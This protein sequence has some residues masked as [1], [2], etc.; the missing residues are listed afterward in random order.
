MTEQK[1]HGLTSAGII[2]TYIS[3]GLEIFFLAPLCFLI[4]TNFFNQFLGLLTTEL[5]IFIIII[6]TH[7]VFFAIFMIFL[8][9]FHK[10]KIKSYILIGIMNLLF[11]NPLGGILILVGE[12]ISLN[13][14]TKSN[15]FD[16]L[17]V[18]LKNLENLFE[19]NIITKDEYE[20]KRKEIINRY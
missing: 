5:L 9:L 2:L 6:I 15:T 17:E 11:F 3:F 19:K 14:K 12:S 13:N 1:Y 10:R 8:I 20:T 7:I 18:K 16:N 4:G